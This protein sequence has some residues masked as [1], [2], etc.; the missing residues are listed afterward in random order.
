MNQVHTVAGI[1]KQALHQHLKR[2]QQAIDSGGCLLERATRLRSGHPGV[3]CRKLALQLRCRGWGRDK[4]ERLL[5]DNGYRVQYKPDYTRTTYRQSQ[6]YYP[7]L[8]EGMELNNINRLVQTDI[9]YY[10][11]NEQFYYLTFIIDVYSRYISGY[12]LSNSLHAQSNIRALKMLLKTRCITPESRLIHHSD[13]GSQYIDKEYTALLKQYGISISMCDEAWKNAY[14]ERVN[15]T[16][17]EEYLD[18]WSIGNYKQLKGALGK[19][20]KHYNQQRQHQSLGWISPAQ[21]EQQLQRI[22]KSM[23]PVMRLYPKKQAINIL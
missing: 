12:S 9:T 8:A 17:K 11:V 20:V 2:R 3:G 5:L 21:F 13:R 7:N 18:G 1:S 15:R 6:Y 14:S 23:Y 10:R 4:I 16:I 19:A 22:D